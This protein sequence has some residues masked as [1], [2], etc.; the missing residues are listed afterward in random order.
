[1]KRFTFD[2]AVDPQDPLQVVEFVSH[3]TGLSKQRIKS[4][5]TKGALWRKRGGER[6]GRIRRAQARVRPGDIIR[7]YYDEKLLSL[8][9]AEAFCLLEYQRYS[10]W[11]KPAGML[12]QGTHFGDHTSLLRQVEKRLSRCRPRLVHRLD[13]ETLGLVMVAHDRRAAGNLSR[14]FIQDQI[15]KTYRAEVFGDITHVVGIR[16]INHPIDGKP[17]LTEITHIW[18][19]Q[20]GKT[21]L[22]ELVLH[23]GRTHQ[24]RRH[25]A[26]VGFPIMGDPK[27]GRGNSHPGGLQLVAWALDWRCPFTQKKRRLHLP[28]EFMLPDLINPG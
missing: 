6:F 21:S 26:D 3:H 23:T 7:L 19:R 28:D 25:L 4:A 17:A 22:L 20:Q 9:V 13:R 11:Y 24:I 12:T 10:I 27:Y 16:Q 14:L 15:K 5:M 8:P 18:P 1:M 2:R